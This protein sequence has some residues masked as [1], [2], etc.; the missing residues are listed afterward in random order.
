MSGWVVNKGIM[1]NFVA[2]AR[3]FAP[4]LGVTFVDGTK[5]EWR[6]RT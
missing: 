4:D 1:D 3:A 2:G 6:Y 5:P